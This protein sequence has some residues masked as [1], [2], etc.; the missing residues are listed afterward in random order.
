MFLVH[1]AMSVSRENHRVPLFV[2]V[3][4][5]PFRK[6]IGSDRRKGHLSVPNHC[7]PDGKV[8]LVGRVSPIDPTS[9]EE[10]DS[11]NDQFRELVNKPRGRT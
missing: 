8:P 4:I 11:S 3:I 6:N 2:Q 9:E 7:P 10:D 5:I 1:Q